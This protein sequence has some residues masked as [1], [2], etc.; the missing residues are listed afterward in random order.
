MN[1]RYIIL[2]SNNSGFD[3]LYGD[4]FDDKFNYNTWFISNYLSLRVR[5]LHIP[6]DGIFNM[7]Y[8]SITKDVDSVKVESPSALNVRLHVE[9]K[10]IEK[11]LS[12]SEEAVR[13]EYYLSLLERGYRLAS[14]FRDI[15]INAF[16]ELH[17]DFRNDGYKNERMFKKMQL[18][19]YGIKVELH[20]VLSSYSY[21]LF[22]S[23]YDLCGNLI[24]RNSIY[25]TYPDDIFFNKT[26][27]HILIKDSKL[28][29]CDFLNHPQFVCSLE[30]LRKGIVKSE[31]VDEHTR[32][33]IPNEKNAADF[34][35]LKW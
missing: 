1:Y 24:G 26:V 27:R 32:E 5:K 19:D 2:H 10:E 34:E 17:R 28:I 13:Y 7:F 3:S 20:H 31:C 15:P 14:T 12:F 11:Y 21:N 23:V 35:R 18:R 33:Y 4:K 25:E 8:C 22:L 6:S 16:L 30:D 29:I 9:E